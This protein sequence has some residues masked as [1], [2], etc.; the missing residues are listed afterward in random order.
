[1]K[2]FVTH[3][4]SFDFKNELYLPLRTSELNKNHSIYL[5]QEK[6]KEIITKDLI[7]NSDIVIAEVSYASTGQGI[8][9]GW[10]DIFKI[11]IVCVYKESIKYSSSLNKLTDKFIVYKNSDDLIKKLTLFLEQYKDL[12]NPKYLV[13]KKQLDSLSIKIVQDVDASISVMLDAGIWLEESGK[14]PSRW[15]HPKNMNR[16][17]LLQHIEPNE[18]Y[19]VL[20]DGKPAASVVLQDNER[21]QSWKSIDKDKKQSALYIH[22]L[23]VGRQYAGMGLPKVMINFAHLQAKKRKLPLLRLDTIAHEMKLRNIYENLGFHLAGIDKKTAF[24]QMKI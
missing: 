12:K 2:I 15:W 9:L 23:C 17:F 16:S 24:Y 4:S 3:S 18:F 19:T 20:V 7:K 13:V 11:P 1:M 8:E 6:G 22:W 10:A 21:N 5:P 14:N